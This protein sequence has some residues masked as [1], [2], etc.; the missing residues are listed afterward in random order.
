MTLTTRPLRGVLV[1]G[2][3]VLA[4]CAADPFVSVRAGTPPTAASINRVS[5]PSAGML[6]VASA[7]RDAIDSDEA[8]LEDRLA[9]MR[10]SGAV[11]SRGVAPVR[12]DWPAP[13]A[14]TGWWMEPRRSGRHPGVDV[15]GETGDPILSAGPGMV[16][17]A[18]PAPA[19]YGGYGT[20]V[21]IDHGQ[22]VVTLY[23]HLSAIA[24][25]P[26][27]AV[28]AGR[29][30]GLMGTTGFVT[31][32]HLHFEVRVNGTQVDPAAWLPAR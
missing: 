11:A 18:G 25:A 19:G 24:V 16:T 7:A 4:S 15:D 13:G 20:M 2:L 21:L 32:S 9:R 12:L 28:D 6:A 23:A 30:V 27:D 5:A 1:W 8:A 14:L 10:S 31:G 22:G 26:G 29:L 3:I 17:H